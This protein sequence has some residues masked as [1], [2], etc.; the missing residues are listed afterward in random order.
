MW[1]TAEPRIITAG[2]MKSSITAVALFVATVTFNSAV[3]QVVDLRNQPNLLVIVALG[4]CM[5]DIWDE[6]LISNAI[7][8]FAF[9][10]WFEFPAWQRQRWRWKWLQSHFCCPVSTRQR[11]DWAQG[12]QIRIITVIFWANAVL[13]RIPQQ[14]KMVNIWLWRGGKN[15]FGYFI[16]QNEQPVSGKAT[17]GAGTSS[18]IQYVCQVVS[19]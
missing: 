3:E 7:C 13:S 6:Q 10:I 12:H 4:D 2:Q 15:H 1:I 14:W 18:Q 5:K 11:S 19:V 8:A 16:I 17:G 9:F